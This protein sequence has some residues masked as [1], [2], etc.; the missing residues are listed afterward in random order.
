MAQ[1][2]VE[3]LAQGYPHKSYREFVDSEAANEILDDFKDRPCMLDDVSLDILRCYHTK[4]L[5]LSRDAQEELHVL[6]DMI[7]LDMQRVECSHARTRRRARGA[8]QTHLRS[9]AALSADRILHEVRSR[10]LGA[11]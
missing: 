10:I 4:E 9:V 8:E 5:L 3:E 7:V 11:W 1:R 6:A 2:L